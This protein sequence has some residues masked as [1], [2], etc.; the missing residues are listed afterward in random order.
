MKDGLAGFEAG[1]EDHPVPAAVDAL[2]FRHPVRLLRHLCQQAISCLGQRRKVRIVLL[3][4]DQHVSGG[5][6]I[7]I[8]KC[9][10]VTTLSH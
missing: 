3:G 8:T 2:G 10:R 5:L 7:D 4:Y 1:V 6:R 9:N